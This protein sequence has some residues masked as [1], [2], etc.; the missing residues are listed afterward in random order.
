M[1]KTNTAETNEFFKPDYFKVPDF[2]QFQNEFTRWVS[3]FS[4]SFANGKAY[5]RNT[6]GDVVCLDLTGS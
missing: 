3:D 4:K 5:A 2:G 1:A 6:K